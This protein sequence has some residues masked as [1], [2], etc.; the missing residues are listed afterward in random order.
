MCNHI[1]DYYGV[2]IVCDKQ[3]FF[4]KEVN[5]NTTTKPNLDEK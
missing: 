4:T 2:C 1:I 5:S 3:I